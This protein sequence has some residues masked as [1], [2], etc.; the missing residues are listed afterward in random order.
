MTT[1]LFGKPLA[2]YPQYTLSLHQKRQATLLYHW[3]SID[4]LKGLKTLIDAL[5]KGA[6]VT[7]E[8]AKLQGRDALLTSDRWGVRDTS[9]NWSTFVFPALEEFRQSTVWQIAQVANELYGGTGANQCAHI[10]GE[11]SSMWMTPEEEEKFKAQFDEV[12]GYASKH[13]DA[14]GVGGERRLDD[15]GMVYEWRLNAEQFP[16]LPKFRVR[17]DVEGTTGKRPQRTGVYVPQDDPNG[18]LQFAWRG[19]DEGQLGE[20]QTFNELGLRMLASV[21]RDS[22]WIDDAK[23]SKFALDAIARDPNLDTG[24]CTKA[25]IQQQPDLAHSAMAFPSFTTRPCKWYF[26]EMV[27]G[28]YEDA[29]ETDAAANAYKPAPD[30]G[31]CEANQP[32]PREGFWF[33][34]AQAGSRRQFKAGEVMPS[35]GG[36]YG[37]TIWQWDSN[38]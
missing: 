24:P 26:V 10:L 2:G 7:L 33:T 20:M 29:A 13:D 18:T 9:A 8:L 37:L 16:R 12:Y 5:I 28:E 14:A 6:D 1:D 15:F 38:Q 22:V 35:V 3:M 32:C 19:S 31:R 25:D 4:Y 36:D 11:Y 21:G 17:T 34:P 30:Q 27:N 23:M